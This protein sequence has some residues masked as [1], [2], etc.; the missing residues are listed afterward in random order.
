MHF[1]SSDITLGLA[2]ALGALHAIEPGQGKTAMLVY[3]A[4]Q[5]RSFW[6]PVVMGISSSLARSL[7]LILIAMLVHLSHHLFY[8][9]R[10][11][12]TSSAV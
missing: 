5:R 11:V 3:L 8:V 12:S 4:G 7:S 1:H 10:L 9:F 6:H 2:F